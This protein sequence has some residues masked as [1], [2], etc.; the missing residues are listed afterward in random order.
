[1]K[2]VLKMFSI[3]GLCTMSTASGFANDLTPSDRALVNAATTALAT[4]LDPKARQADVDETAE[5]WRM[6][7]AVAATNGSEL[8]DESPSCWAPDLEAHRLKREPREI[9]IFGCLLDDSTLTLADILEHSQVI[10]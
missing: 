4:L 8:I 9:L 5:R 1:M 2:R 7:Q 10:Q 3:A 6:A